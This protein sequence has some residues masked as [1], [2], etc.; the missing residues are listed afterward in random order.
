MLLQEWCDH[1]YMMENHTIWIMDGENNRWQYHACLELRRN[2]LLI[3]S[4]VRIALLDLG[5][6]YYIL[7]STSRKMLMQFGVYQEK[8]GLWESPW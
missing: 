3:R 4:T 7:H 6:R 5:V 1:I 8:L 2:L